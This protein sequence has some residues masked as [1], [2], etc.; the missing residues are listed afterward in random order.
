MDCKINGHEFSSPCKDSISLKTLIRGLQIKS[1]GLNLQ[2]LYKNYRFFYHY[3]LGHTSLISFTV[4][5]FKTF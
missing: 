5:V 3:I 1:L 2:I 4:G